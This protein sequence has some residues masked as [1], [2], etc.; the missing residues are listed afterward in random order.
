MSTI[1]YD[2]MID[3]RALLDELALVALT[4]QQE[5]V[6]LHHIDQTYHHELLDEILTRL[7]ES[8]H[9]GF[10]ILFA[11]DPA[12]GAIW[13][14][15]LTHVPSIR[16]DISKRSQAVHQNLRETVLDQLQ[17]LDNPK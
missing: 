15:L 10:F 5:Q 1:F 11:R 12:S 9:E 6:L 3:I 17:A 8:A 13:D 7:P 16:D 2:E 14:Y 4:D